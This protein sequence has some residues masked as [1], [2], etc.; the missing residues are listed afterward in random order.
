MKCTALARTALFLGAA[1]VLVP[2]A[3]AHDG[4]PLS[5]DECKEVWA[6]AS[7]NGEAISWNVAGSYIQAFMLADSDQDGM[8]SPEEFKQ[9][10]A[11]GRVVH[12]EQAPQSEPEP[13]K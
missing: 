11:D 8:I 5:D 3:Q 2:S 6:R 4:E 10:C 7:P 1:L 12:L 13:G 9:A